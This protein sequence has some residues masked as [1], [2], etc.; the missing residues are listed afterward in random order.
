MIIV[1]TPFNKLETNLGQVVALTFYM[2]LVY[3]ANFKKKTR[4]NLNF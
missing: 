3:S 2:L 4:I 1:Y